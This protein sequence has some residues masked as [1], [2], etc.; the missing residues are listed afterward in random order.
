MLKTYRDPTTGKIITETGEHIKSL[1]D[2]EAKVAA[3]QISGKP[4]DI[5]KMPS[6]IR[7]A[8]GG[9]ASKSGLAESVLNLGSLKSNTA[10]L[11]A[12]QD[13]IKRKATIQQPLSEMKA[14]WRTLQKDMSPFGGM[15]DEALEMPGVFKDERMRELSPGDQASIR[16]AR[17]AAASSHL[18]GIRE[19]EEYRLT[20]EEDILN[21]MT[22]LLSEKEQKEEKNKTDLNNLALAAAK[23]G[24]DGNTIKAILNSK[25]Y[26]DGVVK[27]SAY[28]KDKLSITDQ[29]NLKENNYKVD[30]NGNLYKEQERDPITGVP[31]DPSKLIRDYNFTSYARDDQWGYSVSAIIGNM[32]SFNSITDLDKYIKSKNST[33][34]NQSPNATSNVASA[35]WQAAQ[36]RN[37]PV[38]ILTAVLQHESG[39]ATSPV[40]LKNNN[41]GGYTWNPSMGEALK[42][43]PRPA[44]EGGFYVKFATLTDGMKAIAGNIARRYQEPSTPGIEHKFWTEA[45]VRSLAQ[46]TGKNSTEL[47]NNYTDDQLDELAKSASG[48]VVKNVVKKIPAAALYRLNITQGQAEEILTVSTMGFTDE[49]VKEMMG[50]LGMNPSNLDELKKLVEEQEK[51]IP[52]FMKLI[53]WSQE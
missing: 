39:F 9:I 35:I 36:S 37:I 44:D 10:F 43:T 17:D 19:E 28:L 29:I 47:W 42:G 34:A 49:E 46:V 45:A 3:G 38:D 2:Y 13:I 18:Q 27:A 20:R 7:T 40:A 23:G 12:A 16:T 21:L 1:A 4:E 26:G 11:T 32:P 8:D 14:Y 53:M 5:S 50:E 22:D 41:P 51:A 31:T 6:I 24:A 33:I 25:T 30:E 52:E 15:R 48:D